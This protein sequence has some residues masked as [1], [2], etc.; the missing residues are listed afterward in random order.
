MFHYELYNILNLQL[1]VLFTV[2]EENISVSKCRRTFVSRQTGLVWNIIYTSLSQMNLYVSVLAHC[3]SWYH[4]CINVIFLCAFRCF[5]VVLISMSVFQLM[6]LSFYHSVDDFYEAFEAHGWLEEITFWRWFP[7][8]TH[9]LCCE[10]FIVAVSN[11]SD[12]LW[13][14]V[15]LKSCLMW[16]FCVS[17]VLSVLDLS[18]KAA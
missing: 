15:Y 8:W 14:L 1:N 6:F 7:A 13:S 16:G 2:Q 9:G 3:E 18:E 10:H 17:S 5:I 12:K 11:M 4:V